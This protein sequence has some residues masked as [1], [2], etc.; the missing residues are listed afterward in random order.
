MIN[1]PSR[2]LD[3]K[4]PLDILS[5]ALG[6]VEIDRLAISLRSPWIG[7]SKENQVGI[8]LHNC[9]LYS[10]SVPGGC[11]VAIR[12]VRYHVTELTN[13]VACPLPVFREMEGS[14]QYSYL[15][16]YRY[17]TSI[18][19]SMKEW[20]GLPQEVSTCTPTLTGFDSRSAIDKG[21][22]ATTFA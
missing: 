17:Y 1:L 10:P 20:Q 19:L 5:Q 18:P 4:A 3:W 12:S 22:P 7:R 13:G 2:V 21:H 6:A 14:K 9:Q 15:G 8:F 16:H 11:G